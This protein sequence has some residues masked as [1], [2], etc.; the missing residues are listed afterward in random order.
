MPVVSAGL[1]A[2]L[3][4]DYEYG[5]AFSALAL[6]GFYILLAT[7]LFRKGGQPLRMLS[8]SFLATGVVFAT[9]AI[10][11]A[12]DGHITSA[13]WALEGAA[14]LWVGLR[15]SRLAPRIFGSLLQF[16]AGLFYLGDAYRMSQ[17]VPVLN[18]LFLGTIL[19]AFAG[20]FSSYY[21]ERAKHRTTLY[22]QQLARLFFI[23][24]FVWWLGGCIREIEDFSS[25]VAQWAW[26]L[27]VLAL[28]AVLS[29]F[30]K[31]RLG[32][33]R[34]RLA[35]LG[36]LPLLLLAAIGMRLDGTHPLM[37]WGVVAWPAA[38]AG[39]YWLLRHYDDLRLDVIRLWHAGGFWLIVF[40]FSYEASWQLNHWVAG[41]YTWKMIPWGLAPMLM[42]MAVLKYGQLLAWPVGRFHAQYTTFILAPVMIYLLGW[43]MLVNLTSRGDPWPL[44]YLP[45]INPLDLAILFSVLVLIKWWRHARDWLAG[46][47]VTQRGYFSVI[48]AVLFM[49][50]N[51]MVVRS[52]HHWAKVPFY[53]QAMFDSQ[54]FQASISVL[55]ALLGLGAMLMGTRLSKRFIW[56][57]GAGL[58]GL[59]VLKL[60]VVD[61]SNTGTVARIV[62]FIGVG[63]LLLIVGYFSPAPPRQTTKETEV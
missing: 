9:L 58:M 16:L 31:P 22:E 54:V 1:Q 30:L 5:L 42:V 46:N 40:L 50:L 35:A 2:A 18:G 45:V 28:T 23:W 38:L 15:Q 14:L 3:V 36:L 27:G 4:R 56:V 24:G 48:G 57:L 61:L 11:F 43:G 13:F 55:W 53:A 19:I 52:V 8:E 47:G 10:P 62:S 12:F 60:F 41:S 6:G 63:L 49:W 26:L 25:A 7:L 34:L 21:L 29:E 44:E 37:G 32:W 51:G 20:L 59:V 33:P 39:H 17:D